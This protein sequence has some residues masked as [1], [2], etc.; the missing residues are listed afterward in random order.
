MIRNKQRNE[1]AVE[2]SR[3]AKAWNAAFPNEV[4]DLGEV[5]A[6]MQDLCHFAGLDGKVLCSDIFQRFADLIDPDGENDD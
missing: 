3:E 4:C 6:L 2:F 5:P 1:V